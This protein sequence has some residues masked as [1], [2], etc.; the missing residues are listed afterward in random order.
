MSDMPNAL[1]GMNCRLDFA[2][3]KI[4]EHEHIVTE[5]IQNTTKRNLKKGI[6]SKMLK[7]FNAAKYI[8]NKI[9]QRPVWWEAQKNIEKNNSQEYL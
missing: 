5:T 9:P 8:C 2:K 7:N 6:A 3:E 4:S 1:D